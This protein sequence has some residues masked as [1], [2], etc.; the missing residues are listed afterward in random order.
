[1]YTALLN[2]GNILPQ[3]TKEIRTGSGEIIKSF[4][5]NIW[6]DSAMKEETANTLLP[7]LIDVVEDNTGT[8]H[9]L[10]I[11]NLK[12]G[13]KTGTAQLGSEKEEELAWLVAFTVDEESPLLLTVC[14]E[15]SAG[16]GKEKFDI[17]KSIFKEY[18]GR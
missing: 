5:T 9:S 12:L 2:N 17:A 10:Q 16:Q 3:L 4:K 13:A 18:Y 15:V 7:Y 8:A 11:P 14:L 6:K 1:M